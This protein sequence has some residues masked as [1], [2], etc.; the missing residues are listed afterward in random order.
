MKVTVVK[1]SARKKGNSNDIVNAFCEG[2]AEG[3]EVKTYEMQSLKVS[4]CIGC[5]ICKTKLERCA[6]KDEL[7]GVYD[8]VHESDV[9]VLSTPVYFGDVNAQTKIFIDRLYHLFTPDFHEGIDENGNAQPDPRYSRL[10]R[11][12]KLVFIVAQGSPY[13]AKYADVSE[14]YE[15][16]FRFLGFEEVHVIRGIG[17]PAYRPDDNNAQDAFARARALGQEFCL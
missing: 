10:K 7:S 17:D 13:E 2:L 16:F 14:R 11:G 6:I 5:M 15:L 8:D 4:G 3:T 12:T 9:V 1:G